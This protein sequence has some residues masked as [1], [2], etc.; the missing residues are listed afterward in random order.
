M[1]GTTNAK[2]TSAKRGKKNPAPVQET[3]VSSADA[4]ASNP[5][6]AQEPVPVAEPAAPAP[7]PVKGRRTR[8]EP[9]P[10]TP[11]PAPA[12][13]PVVEAPVP[14]PVGGSIRRPKKTPSVADQGSDSGSE[15]GNK[16]SFTITRI[17][18]NGQ[19]STE[20]LKGRYLSKNP[21]SASRKASNKMFKKLY[22]DG[23]AQPL[24]IHLQETTKGSK[25]G[26][27]KYLCTRESVDARQV[28]FKTKDGANTGMIP[29]KYHIHV[30]S[31]NKPVASAQA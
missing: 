1:A 19:E 17:V 10:T 15:T 11:T 13:E 24:E 30:K 8:K 31:L 25:R 29:F 22:Q 20:G 27:F 2:T 18:C 16:R 6:P 21:A 12:S 9:I 3:S 5:V 26:E 14:V 28:S 7:V 4:S 23:D